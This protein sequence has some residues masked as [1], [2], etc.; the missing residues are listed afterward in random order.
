MAHRNNMNDVFGDNGKASRQ[1]GGGWDDEDGLDSAS[2]E[3]QEKGRDPGFGL[4]ESDGEDDGHRAGGND[5]SGAYLPRSNA[6]NRPRGGGSESDGDQ[7]GA[8]GKGGQR[9][10]Q[11]T[12]N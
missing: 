1:L 11:G 2:D 9:P 4:D 8:G 10:G 7:H 12:K 6:R 5:D 3:K